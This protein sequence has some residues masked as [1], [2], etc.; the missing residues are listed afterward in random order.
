MYCPECIDKVDVSKF[1]EKCGMEAPLYTFKFD[2]CSRGEHFCYSCA[3]EKL[4][5]IKRENSRRRFCKRCKEEITEDIGSFR[6][7]RPSGSS[8]VLRH[9]TLRYHEGCLERAHKAYDKTYN[10]RK[11]QENKRLDHR[12]IPIKHGMFQV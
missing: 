6:L 12:S 3:K 1:C 2:N 7:T 11:Y 5:D 10:R 4:N 8:V 9:R